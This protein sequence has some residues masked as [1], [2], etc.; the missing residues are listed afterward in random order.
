[1]CGIVGIAS[2]DWVNQ[3]LYHTLIVLQHRGQDAAGI[4][5]SEHGR[6]HWRRS[7]GM[8]RDVFHAGHML[9]L[10]GRV[11]IGH[12]RYPTAGGAGSSEAQP[13][14]VNSPFGVALA[15]N[16][17]LINADELRADLVRSDRRHLNTE[18]DSEVLL[19]VFAHELQASRASRI[20]EEDIFRAVAGVHR[21]CTGGYAA[22]ALVF[23]F[24][25]VAFR[26]P[27]G[28]R[29]LALGVREGPRG[30]EY[31][32][33]S[34]SVAVNAVGFEFLRDVEPGEAVCV[35]EGGGLSVRQCAEEPSRS[36]CIFEYVYLARPDSVL[37]GIA[38]YRARLRMGERL[39]ERI[40]REAPDHGIDVVI[41]IP[42]TSRTAA[43][44]LSARLGVEYREG[45]VKN[46]YVGRTFIMPGQQER[47]RSVRQKLNAIASE[48]AGKNVLLVDDSI[49]RGTTSRQIIDMAREAGAKRVYFASGAPPVRYPNVYG[50]DMPTS[51]ELIA[52][53]RTE[54]QIRAEIGADRLF[55]QDIDDLERAVA[56]DQGR[57]RTF[58]TS[59]FTGDYVT[60]GVTEEFLRRQDESR[61]D[62]EKK[63]RADA[64][65]QE[66]ADLELEAWR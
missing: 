28:I 16:G 51:R 3:S 8:V 18:S 11:G 1:M 41:P 33:A 20:R 37:D 9:A 52:F 53:N 5:T 45:F 61:N 23:G 13:F 43:L 10:R 35:P 14:Y 27:H 57:I 7:N 34:E 63:R 25:L 32:V 49:V 56:G 59:C 54:E 44:P 47:E 6:L 48:F 46:R 62:A 58:D 30:K 65:R 19:N 42:E 55:Y 36:P 24:G 64:L 12:V 17:N 60:G 22:V 38:V 31:M 15:H 29:P 26:D 2:R 50:I 39:A 66:P 21:R 4:A 40:L